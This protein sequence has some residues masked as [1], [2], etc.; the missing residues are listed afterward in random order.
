MLYGELL[1]PKLKPQTA[2]QTAR[3]LISDGLYVA[4]LTSGS[5]SFPVRLRIN[6][7]RGLSLVSMV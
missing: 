5:V 7:R 3:F 1:M 6:G 4:V 2:G